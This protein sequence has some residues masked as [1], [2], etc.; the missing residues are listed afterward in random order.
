[1]T[2]G[3]RKTTEGPLLLALA[4]GA[5]VAEAARQAGVSEPTVYRRL[6]DTAFAR[7]LAEARGAVIRQ[8]VGRLARD[9]STAADTL[10]DLLTA[11]SETVRLGAARSILE[12]TI[13][14][15]DHEDIESRIAALEQ[16]HVAEVAPKGGRSWGA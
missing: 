13:K 16:Q 4:G 15:R 14:I 11:D 8:A 1:M 3:D 10:A 12:L 5:T 7:H 2:P 9:C 6:R